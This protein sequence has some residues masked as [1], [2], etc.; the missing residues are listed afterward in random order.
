MTSGSLPPARL[1]VLCACGVA[2][3]WACLELLD[4]LGLV[5]GADW[6]R[7]V[8]NNVPTAPGAAGAAGAGAGAA[9]AASQRRTPAAPP[10]GPDWEGLAESQRQYRETYG[11]AAPPAIHPGVIDRDVAGGGG[12]ERYLDQNRPPGPA[13]APPPTAVD[14][15]NQAYDAWTHTVIDSV[16]TYGGKVQ[17]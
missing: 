3:T 10:T 14:R 13:A 16:L 4:V 1:L 17:R 2:A 5:F 9:G 11:R 12:Y 6:L 8:G 7:D 15:A